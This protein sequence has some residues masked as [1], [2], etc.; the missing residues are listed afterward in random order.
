MITEWNGHRSTN[1]S[2]SRDNRFISSYSTYRR[3]GL[4]PRCRLITSWSWKRF[5][6]FGCSPTKVV[7]ELG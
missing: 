3:A 7:R 6:G 1:K 5:Q 4:I 2:Y